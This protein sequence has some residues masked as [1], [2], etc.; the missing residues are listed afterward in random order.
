[1]I[2]ED[3]KWGKIKKA[4]Q[5]KRWDN[6]KMKNWRM[7]F[8]VWLPLYWLWLSLVIIISS[9][10]LYDMISMKW[11]DAAFVQWFVVTRR[12]FRRKNRFLS[13]EWV[14]SFSF[15][16][17]CCYWPRQ[18]IIKSVA[19][20]K[21]CEIHRRRK[22][23]IRRDKAKIHRYQ[24]DRRH[25]SSNAFLHCPFS[26]KKAPKHVYSHFLYSHFHSFFPLLSFYT[27]NTLTLYIFIHF[28]TFDIHPHSSSFITN[29]SHNFPKPESLSASIN[30][31]TI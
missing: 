24:V 29:N 4:Q 6:R 10:N 25:L 9:S 31:D 1:M 26:T 15:Y 19:S 3:I 5:F 13:L 11:S 17:K 12:Y 8:F 7:F 28:I 23:A 2:S 27:Y 21:R 16:Q 30:V 14:S 22:T 18:D 20:E